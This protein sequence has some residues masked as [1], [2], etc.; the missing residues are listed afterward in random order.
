MSK[1]T[2]IR[3]P[4]PYSGIVK[5]IRGENKRKSKSTG[6]TNSQSNGNSK[7][8]AIVKVALKV[9]GDMVASARL[10]LTRRNRSRKRHVPSA[11]ARAPTPAGLAW[12][13]RSRPGS[14]ARI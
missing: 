3:A 7:R 5:G 8:T 6:I 4:T 12:S 2:G 1:E 9:K 13:G 10:E 14:W 11:M